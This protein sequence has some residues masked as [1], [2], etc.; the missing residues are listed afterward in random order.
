MFAS[1]LA[2]AGL[3]GQEFVPDPDESQFNIQVQTPQ[4]TSLAATSAVMAEIERR[5]ADLPGVRET[6][7]TIG[8]GVEQRVNVATLLVRM[9]PL[10]QRNISQF[11]AM[12]LAR[13]RLAD[14]SHLKL[15]VEVVPR[16]SGGGMRTAPVQYNVRGK[17]LDE[18]AEVSE[19]IRSE[20]ES[21]PGIVDLVSTH[22]DGKPE[23]RVDPDREKAAQLDV[24]VRDIGEAVGI[25]IGGR[26][27][28]TYEQGGKTY[29]V[30]VRLVENDRDRIEAIRRVPVRTGGGELIDL[31]NLVE[32]RRETGPVQIDRQDRT[33]QVTLMANLEKSKPLAAAMEDFAAAE[34]RVGL[35]AGVTST[36]TGHAETMG[37]SFANIYFSLLLAVVLIYM[38]LAAQ[39]ESLVH[40]LTVMLSL[41]L[42]IV[43]ALGLLAVTGR[44]LNIFSMIGM[45]MLMGLVTKNA[46]LLIDYT[47]LMRSKGMDRDDAVLKAGPVRLRPILMTACSTIAG[48]IPVAIGLGSGAEQRAPMG[49]CIV[50]GMLTSTVL[51]LVA[52][53]VIYTLFDDIAVTVG[54]LAR[55]ALGAAAGQQ[56]RQSD[57]AML[58]TPEPGARR[59]APSPVGAGET[60]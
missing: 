20:L 5:V 1:S 35:P 3:I 19:Q 38:V 39:F 34:K 4:G 55:G 44:T 32:I 22:D 46:I 9:A 15:S 30:R 51:T 53:P 56:D 40:P 47:N 10:G 16:V 7:T 12:R 8:S 54:R 18:L 45:I 31:D 25:L 24:P 59:D 43:G 42:S 50:G 29:D 14:L 2:I 27:A 41:P 23:A 57:P 49:T 60:A 28:S 33:R 37:E 58:P 13:R 36:F 11:D 48:M 17:D 26:K 6:F 52:T 21:V